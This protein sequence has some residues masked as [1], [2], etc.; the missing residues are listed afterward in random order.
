[1]LQIQIIWQCG[2]KYLNDIE[3]KF[4]MNRYPNVRLLAYIND[5]PAAYAVAD[6]VVSRA[7][8]SSCSELM[9]TGTP[10][11]LVPSPNVAGDH[12][13][14]N[15]KSM[16][17]NNAAILLE[18]SEVEAKLF[19][20]IN[21]LIHNDKKLA[22]MSKSA[23]RLAKPDAADKIAGDVLDLLQTKSQNS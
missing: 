1:Q 17:E 19:E 12:Q 2:K 16:V 8:A 6:L 3:N 20:K 10:S 7:G 13:K 11:I 23:F 14:K 21:D 5:M 18:D 22:E 9:V 4:D 15:A